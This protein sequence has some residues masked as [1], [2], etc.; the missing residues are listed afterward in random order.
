MAYWIK[1]LV[2]KLNGEHN[3]SRWRKFL[4]FALLRLGDELI[5]AG[6]EEQFDKVEDT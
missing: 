6:V 1:F 3:L 4:I 2:L 5:R